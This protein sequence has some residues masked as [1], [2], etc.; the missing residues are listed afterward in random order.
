MVADRHCEV[1]EAHLVCRELTACRCEVLRP[2][3]TRK[4]HGFKEKPR[5][6]RGRQVKPEALLANLHS[7]RLE[8]AERFVD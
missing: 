6:Y 8:A 3:A 2:D 1:L 4:G 5:R 7:D